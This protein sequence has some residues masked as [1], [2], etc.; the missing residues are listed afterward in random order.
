MANPFADPEFGKGDTTAPNPFSDPSFG[1]PRSAVSYLASQ[2]KAG[3][4]ADL[5]AIAGKALQYT[6]KPGDFLHDIGSSWRATGEANAAEAQTD[7]S[8]GAVTKLAAGALRGAAPIVP[9]AAAGLAANVF[10]PQVAVPLEL[11]GAAGLAAGFGGSQAQDTL[12]KARAAGMSEEQAVSTA[13]KT[14]AITG[15]GMGA[16]GALTGGIAA[17][18]IRAI[19]GPAAKTAAESLANVAAPKFARPF[20]AETAGHLAGNVASMAAANAGVAGVE[21]AAGLPGPTPGQAALE[22][23][24]SGA[25]L[26]AALLPFGLARTA[27]AR[28][29]NT[30]AVNRLQSADTD[31]AQRAQIAA[32]IHANLKALDPVA[33]NHFADNVANAIDGK[34]ALQLG[35]HLLGPLE[36]AP[37]PGAPLALPAPVVRVDEQGNARMDGV[38]PPVQD[39]AAAAVQGRA[40]V[41]V[42]SNQPAPIPALPAPT[43]VVDSQGNALTAADRQAAREAGLRETG[44]MGLGRNSDVT[45]VESRPLPSQAM[46]LD[47][48]AGPI[49]RA[50][51]LAVDSGAHQQVT[52][53]A[54]QAAAMEAASRETKKPGAKVA[55]T[56]PDQSAI[57]AGQAG[58][59]DAAG[60]ELR[61]GAQPAVQLAQPLTN[62]IAAGRAKAEE[63]NKFPAGKPTAAEDKLAP[64]TAALRENELDAVERVAQ[65]LPERNAISDV[66]TRSA[67]RLLGATE[68]EI[69]D[70]FTAAAQ[71]PRVA[72]ADSA[73]AGR[74]EQTAKEPAAGSA[75][76]GEE[77][78]RAAKPAKGLSLGI[79][80]GN[81]EAVSVKDGLIHIGKDPAIHFDTGEPI[82][83]KAGATDAELKQA[84]KDAGAISRRQKFYGGQ[85]EAEPAPAA[86]AGP[87]A[88]KSEPA[89]AT[90]GTQGAIARSSAGN[91]EQGPSPASVRPDNWRTNF[92][93][94]TQV[95][96]GVGIPYE[97]GRSLA[98]VL[99]LVDAKDGNAL[100]EKPAT[101][102]ITPAVKTE[103]PASSISIG[104]RNLVHRQVSAAKSFV[105]AVV[106]QFGLTREQ[107]S[108]A[109]DRMMKDKLVKLDA[110]SGQFQ[111]KDGRAWDKDVMRRAAGIEEPKALPSSPEQ[112]PAA[113]KP[114]A[115]AVVAS[116]AVKAPEA[117]VHKD[118]GKPAEAATAPVIA[119]S[120]KKGERV[121][122]QTPAMMKAN[123]LK[124]I[125]E[126]HAIASREMEREPGF[127]TFDVPGDGV[128]KVR[129][130][131][132]GLAEFRAK[133][134]KSPG[135]SGKQSKPVQPRT[136]G[137]GTQQE[138]GAYF[139]VEKGS[140]DAR[141][142]VQNM[143]EERDFQA[144]LDYATAKGVS[145]DALK[146]SKD[147]RAKLDAW[148]KDN[149]TPTSEKPEPAPEPRKVAAEPV[150]APAAE[151]KAEPAKSEPP[152]K[153]NVIAEGRAKAEA[154]NDR[155][156]FTLNRLNRETGEMQP[157]TFTR[158]EYVRYRVGNEDQFGD[159]DG[160]SHA[161]SEFS[162]DGLWHPLGFAYKAERPEPA[163][164]ATV[165]ISKVIDSINKKHG[166]GLTEADRVPAKVADAKKLTKAQREN[167]AAEAARAAYF[168]PGNIVKG[169]AGHDEVLSYTAPDKPGGAWSVKV[170]HVN[171]VGDEWVREGK[172][173]SARNHSTQPEP[174]EMKAGP[175]ATLGR[176]L[177]A[178]VKYAQPRADGKPFPDAP[179]R[180]P[181][182]KTALKRLRDERAESAASEMLT[183]E[184][185]RQVDR[186]SL[187]WEGGPPIHVVATSAEMPGNQTHNTAGLFTREGIYLAADRNRTAQQV[188]GTL[189]HEVIAHYGLRNML[190]RERWETFMDN[191]TKALERGNLPLRALQ[192]DIRRLY[193]DEKGQFN[194]S[195][196]IEADEIAARAIEQSVDANGNL[197]PGFS[198]LKEVYSHVAEFLRSIGI[199]VKFSMAELQGMMV[200]SQKAME[201]GKRFE[202]REP[203][204]VAAARG[205]QQAL[206]DFAATGLQS[207]TLDAA[208]ATIDKI[209]EDIKS[210]IGA[211]KGGALHSIVDGLMLATMP[212]KRSGE[213]GN[214]ATQLRYAQGLANSRKMSDRAALNKAVAESTKAVT[215]A[216]KARDA[217]TMGLT[218]A[219][220]L[221]VGKPQEHNWA[222]M[223]AMDSP[224]KSF[225]DK[226]PALKEVAE[227]MSRLWNERAELI[228]KLD[229][230]ALQNLRENYFRHMWEREPDADTQRQIFST[231]S[232]RPFGQAPGSFKERVYEDFMAGVKAG[233]KP[234]SDNPMDIFALSMHELDKYII[235]HGV[236]KATEGTNGVHL[237]TTGDKTPQGY[238]DINGRFGNIE[239]NGE[240]LRYV[241]RDDVAQV[242]NNYVSQSLYHNKYVGSAFTKYMGAA[243]TLNQFQLGVF[244][245]F[246]A[247]FTSMEAVISHGALGVKA[248][249]EGDWKGAA[250]YMGT[251]PAAWLNNPRLGDKIL[252]EWLNRGSHP[253]VAHIISALEMAGA[254]FE[255]DHRFRTDY[256]KNM[257]QAWGEGKKFKAGINSLGAL[258]EQSA[259]PIL[260]WLVPRQKAGVFGE[261]W[262]RWIEKNPNATHEE[263]LKS[264]QQIWNRVDSRLGQ[265]V[266][267]RLF[268][269][270]VA[271]NFAQMLI[272]APGWTGGTILEV[273]GGLKDLAKYAKDLPLALA[274][275]E[276]VQGMTDRAAYTFSMLMTTAIANAAMTAMFTGEAPQDWKDLVAF[277]SGN[278]DENGRP[279]RFMLPTYMK[280]VYAYVKA[281][282]TTL[283]NKSHPLLSL[284]GDIGRNRD[285]YGTE[286]RSEDD[287]LFTQLAQTAGFAA[288]AFV[289][290][291]MKGV[292]KEKERGGSALAMS[293]PS[294]GVMPAPSGMDKTPAEALMSKYS[295]DR[296]PQGTRT[297]EETDKAN[298]RRQMY[299]A[300]RKGEQDK[301]REVFEQG[302][303]QGLF[304][305]RDYLKVVR[306]ARQ[307]PVVNSFSHLTYEQAARVMKVAS[308]E[309]KQELAPAFM[310]KRIAWQRQHQGMAAE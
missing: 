159:I 175:V 206:G 215:L 303:E 131:P 34:Q 2:A 5:P 31:P 246:H 178:E 164:P 33:A 244:S 30:A 147:D 193:V 153:K 279:E 238:T 16:V 183:A 231:L 179:D 15:V 8:Q 66:P 134:E 55:T 199:D 243:N 23:V 85:V 185:R 125:D 6:G 232:K 256:T 43:T 259:R 151:V 104:A 202:G 197:R 242:V 86:A 187:K 198:F 146:L 288:K 109:L 283:V 53:Q 107:A 28:K 120:L 294:I 48:A 13:R 290:F 213:A 130:S 19:A 101:P 7:E 210:G 222:F 32:Q 87:A 17:P 277:R 52:E 36:Q 58:G 305:A 280:D 174:R 75:G 71:T 214:V 180:G 26:T 149:P 142:A 56:A 289:P 176:Q 245:A 286:I 165:P 235:A 72:Q 168:T 124:Q 240:K 128:F 20:V 306:Q 133:V 35:E 115:G 21:Q 263:T 220:K 236:L 61:G 155:D 137:M 141:M 251:A 102:A 10:A 261:M 276:K 127:V 248:A 252:G 144:A 84:L 83:I 237:I 293:L 258:S 255:M 68:P 302:K 171:K 63:A 219:D 138:G 95:A 73:G 186:I 106:E 129:N 229:T 123:L 136:N 3:L 205:E 249:S 40:P 70:A 195:P 167:A 64:H 92:M 190:G 54:A 62:V 217:L 271:K 162:V 268:V 90:G 47:P 41:E 44:A 1:K 169:W 139:G 300:L 94:A 122:G 221:F 49:S 158:G 196:K 203:Q 227:V 161:R 224:D 253:E 37:Q 145:M 201:V 272:R 234:V 116:K 148:L 166:E 93:I 150:K 285:F 46:G 18:A 299:V 67:L 96:K 209:K 81:A 154:L 105:D 173:D 57:A 230:G 228:Q 114:E 59:S 143:V 4:T 78:P 284:V 82:K 177:G 212:D 110:I 225:L 192:R 65:H 307:D 25:S 233:L 260:E 211:T 296:L 250:K 113:A 69:K 200:R 274:K 254:R 79:T 112:P 223:Q 152:A 281:P 194:L 14:G 140:T 241:A 189:A 292:Q 266:Y 99:A 118:P 270:N 38:Q 170:H 126:A 74:P 181:D 216:E 132:E 135:F 11:A 157:V 208:S 275:G 182:L 310:K 304:G 163:K 287:N 265:V 172:P 29:A 108:T 111:L 297:Q 156:N 45:D 9:L 50:A 27:L 98:D 42:P 301:A 257:M 247:G 89:P 97:K 76:R 77:A 269:H 121:G 218:K 273:G 295:A 309:E 291:W 22:G 80:P 267:D 184:A 119:E 24:E 12:E 282:G 39:E 226:H 51:V 278:L 60:M 191:I 88:T 239:R 103:V 160:I 91:G 100:A 188:G 298:L 117:A 207:R 308:D 264:A 204:L 262:N